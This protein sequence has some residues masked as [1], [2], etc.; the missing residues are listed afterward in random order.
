VLI[1]AVVQ[2]RVGF[3]PRSPIGQ[4]KPGPSPGQNTWNLVSSFSNTFY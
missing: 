4:Y 3:E 1:L 2:D